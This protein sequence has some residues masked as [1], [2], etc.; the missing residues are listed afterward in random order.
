MSFPVLGELGELDEYTVMDKADDDSFNL[1]TRGRI[2]RLG[3]MP[4]PSHATR[5]YHK[6]R[7]GRRSNRQQGRNGNGDPPEMGPNRIQRHIGEHRLVHER[8]AA[9]Y[10]GVY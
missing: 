7:S 6:P 9:G 2:C 10:G 8:A 1:S 4:F 3:T 5:P